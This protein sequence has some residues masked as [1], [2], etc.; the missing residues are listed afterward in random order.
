MLPSQLVVTKILVE[1]KSISTS[2][3]KAALLKSMQVRMWV[4]ALNKALVSDI[5]RYRDKIN[6]IFFSHTFE[7]SLIKNTTV[8]SS[9]LWTPFVEWVTV[10]TY[11]LHCT[12]ISFQTIISTTLSL[13]FFFFD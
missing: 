3:S 13:L 9:N 11:V 12:H 1:L 4:A 2:H 8:S 10:V 6:V 5:G 7:I